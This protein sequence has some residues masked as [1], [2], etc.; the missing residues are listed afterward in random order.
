M[1]RVLKSNIAVELVEKEKVTSS[2]I[3]LKS[4]DPT[5]V[6][7]GLVVAVGPDVTLV[8][9]GDVVLPNWNAAID[10]L[11]YEGQDM[12]IIPER[13]IVGIFEE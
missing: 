9:I 2:G 3:I 4:A 12:F 10:K 8:S 11:S 6:S 5:E 7:K 13:E 1:I